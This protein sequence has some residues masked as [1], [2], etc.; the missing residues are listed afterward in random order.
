MEPVELTRP[1][2]QRVVAYARTMLDGAEHFIVIT[3]QQYVEAGEMLKRV[4]LH[5]KQ[6][7]LEKEKILRPLT[8]AASAV[9]AFFCDPESALNGAE[10]S[11]KRAMLAF[12]VMQEN[13]RKAAQVNADE[14][15][16]QERERLDALARKAELAGKTEKA[17]ALTERAATLVPQIIQPETVKISGVSFRESWSAEVLDFRALVQAVASGDA[18]M[19]CLIPDM[20]FLHAQARALK[21]ELRY[22]GVRA[23]SER[24]IASAAQ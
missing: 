6:V 15:A 23:K 22:P 2:V 16:R 21:A 4:K 7:A 9:R 24:G 1:D 8:A 14:W 12:D 20:R 11:L 17:G 10:S 19:V 5:Q 18:P 13:A 3:P